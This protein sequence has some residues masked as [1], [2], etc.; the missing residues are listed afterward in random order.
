M[1]TGTNIGKGAGAQTGTD[2]GID[3]LAGDYSG[4]V[5]TDLQNSV[6]LRITTPLGSYWDDPE[7]GSLLHTLQREK[8]LLRVK[9]LA[10]QY[11]RQ[12]LQPLLDSQRADNITI[13]VDDLE[14][15]GGTAR[16]FMRVNVYQ[17]GELVAHF[18]HHVQVMQG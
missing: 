5:V 8:D 1:T 7:L 14:E 9:L 17:R 10:E 2:F 3:P 13:E 4:W 11:T 6:Y 16:L 15:L 18:A 12:A